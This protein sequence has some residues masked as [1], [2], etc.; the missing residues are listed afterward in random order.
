[1]NDW[2]ARDIPAPDY[3]MGSLF[4]TTSRVQIAGPT[5]LGKTNFGFALAAAMAA[6]KDFLHWRCARPARVLYVDGEMSRSLMKQRIDDALRRIGGVPRGQLF[7]LC[8]DDVDDMPP[9]NIKIGQNYVDAKIAEIGGVDFVVFDN[10]QSLIPGNM[11]E[12][13]DWAAALPWI[14]SLTKRRIGQLWFHHTG[15]DTSHGYGTSTREWQLDTVGLMEKVDRPGADIAFALKFSKTRQK[16]PANRLDYEPVTVLL[17]NDAWSCSGA[18]KS[19]P[20][21]KPPSPKAQ[22]FYHALTDALA[23][24]GAARV[25]SDEWKASCL[26]RGLLNEADAHSARSLMSKYRL[27]LI[28]ANW[29]C[30]D[31]NEVGLGAADETVAGRLRN[32]RATVEAQ[33][34]QPSRNHSATAP[35]P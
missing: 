34:A 20:A 1:V 28:A 23:A 25:T 31:D 21:K 15:H 12:E 33:P 26:N 35:Q 30:V 27:E 18:S 19:P 24:K 22:A 2:T 4:S 7:C 5:G 9:L 11:K 13:D 3:L 16:T 10:V 6:G 29:V 32:H 8:K 14:K 17:E